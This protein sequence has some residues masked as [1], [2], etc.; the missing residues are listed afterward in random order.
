MSQTPETPEPG[1][2][3]LR[4]A[5]NNLPAHE[6]DPTTWARVEAQ[7]AAEVVLARALPTL[8]AHEPDEGLWATIA[9]RLEAAPAPPVAVPTASAVGR[10]LWPTRT[11]RW[12]LALAASLLLVLGAW[13]Q[14]RPAAWQPAVARETLT[15]GEE[16]GARPRLAPAADPLE[17]QGLAFIDS[18]CSSQPAA[19]QSDEF[20]ALRTQLQELETQEVQLRQDARRFGSSPELLREQT[21]LISLKASFTRQLVHLLIS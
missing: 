16:E 21:R 18:R 2:A 14:L 17:L 8:P 12:A 7:L 20:R 15:F 1:A 6:P 9:A 13:W 5:L 11:R 10:P 19:C 4:R 3:N